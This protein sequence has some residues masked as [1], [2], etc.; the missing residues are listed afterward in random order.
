MIFQLPF[1]KIRE[2][3]TMSTEQQQAILEEFKDSAELVELQKRMNLF[4]TRFLLGLVIVLIA[5]MILLS[6]SG[7][8]VCALTTVAVFWVGIG[9]W[10][11]WPALVV[12]RRLKRYVRTRL[13]EKS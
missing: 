5:L 12:R 1:S 8:I 10:L 4:S 9:M 7:L 2:L 13:S 6:R 3:A 11:L